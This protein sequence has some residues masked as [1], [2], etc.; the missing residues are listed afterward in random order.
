M[1]TES[2]LTNIILQCN[3]LGSQWIY[4]YDFN[5]AQC[6]NKNINISLRHY[7]YFMFCFIS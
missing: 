2:I 1:N 3:K 4:I 6:V 5:M 7:L